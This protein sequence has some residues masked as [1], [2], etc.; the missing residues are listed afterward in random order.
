MFFLQINYYLRKKTIFRNE[1]SLCGETKYKKNKF[2]FL[3]FKVYVLLVVAI[4]QSI[5]SFISV[6][7]KNETVYPH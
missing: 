1:N 2:V 3:I 7:F 5:P 4:T 6:R